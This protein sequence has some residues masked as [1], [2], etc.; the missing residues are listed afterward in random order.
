MLPQE[1]RYDQFVK[2]CKAWRG[3]YIAADMAPL[4]NEMQRIHLRSCMDAVV[5]DYLERYLYVVDADTPELV[6]E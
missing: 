5:D 4:S 2:W 1:C 6:L 3:Y